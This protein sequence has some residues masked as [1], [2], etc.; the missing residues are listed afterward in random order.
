VSVALYYDRQRALTQCALADDLL[1]RTD[2]CQSG[3]CVECNVEES[4]HDSLDR[5][6]NLQQMTDLQ[7]A[8][9][10]P[11]TFGAVQA[12][13]S[14]GRPMCARIVWPGNLRHFVVL[15][16]YR[17]VTDQ[18]WVLIEDPDQ[19]DSTYVFEQF[20]NGYRSPHGIQGQCTHAYWTQPQQG[21]T[22]APQVT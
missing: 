13:L 6:G 8:Q 18:P 9:A 3:G 10:Q 19:G 11:L 2:C 22:C 12:A 1:E 15:F 17:A 14:G 16:G 4:L 21:A 5:T 20:L 7:P